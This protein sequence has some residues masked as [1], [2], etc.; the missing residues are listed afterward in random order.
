MNNPL[1]IVFSVFWI[2]AMIA[3]IFTKSTDPFGAAVVATIIVGFGYCI[4]NK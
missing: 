2:T 1:V 4:A 3:S